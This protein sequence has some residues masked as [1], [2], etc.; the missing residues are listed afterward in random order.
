[1]LHDDVYRLNGGLDSRLAAAVPQKRVNH[2]VRAGL[3]GGAE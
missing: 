2:G 1:M 3:R